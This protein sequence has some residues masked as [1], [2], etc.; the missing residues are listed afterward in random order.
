MCDLNI[1]GINMEAS[2]LFLE[3]GYDR[4]PDLKA[5]AMMG[6]SG[7]GRSGFALMVKVATTV[8]A[9]VATKKAIK[10][11]VAKEAVVVATAKQAE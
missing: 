10:A 6:S 2:V 3:S 9:A 11:M 7:F 4:Q 1:L 8:A 5:A